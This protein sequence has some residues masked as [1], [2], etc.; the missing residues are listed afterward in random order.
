MI[1]IAVSVSYHT[2]PDR[3]A[4]ESFIYWYGALYAFAKKRS[5]K[6]LWLDV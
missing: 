5:F 4:I 2:L 3:N 6:H 1:V